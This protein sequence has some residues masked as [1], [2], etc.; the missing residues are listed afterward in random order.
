MFTMCIYFMYNKKKLQ[1]T[2]CNLRLKIFLCLDISL[3]IQ[4]KKN[5]SILLHL[6]IFHIFF[7]WVILL[8]KIIMNPENCSNYGTQF[9]TG[10][11]G[12]SLEEDQILPLVILLYQQVKKKQIIIPAQSLRESYI[13]LILIQQHQL[14][15]LEVIQVGFP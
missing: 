4:R 2:I 5:A 3:H 15:F 7:L 12:G 8:I 10:L 11:H 6:N 14:L 9:F 1:V 13:P